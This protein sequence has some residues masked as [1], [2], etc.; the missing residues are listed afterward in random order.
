MD[1]LA[2]SINFQQYFVDYIILQLFS[3]NQIVSFDLH[4]IRNMMKLIL[5]AIVFSLTICRGVSDI[6]EIAKTKGAYLVIY[7][8]QN[9]YFVI[10]PIALIINFKFLLVFR[11]HSE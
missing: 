5:F 9:L 4:C 8:D 10:Y 6:K 2:K 7:Q 11:M 1:F 3:L